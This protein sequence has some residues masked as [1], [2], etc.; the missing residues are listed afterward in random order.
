MLALVND[1]G[2]ARRDVNNE[3]A[4]DVIKLM[5]TSFFL[6]LHIFYIESET[7]LC[8]FAMEINTLDTCRAMMKFN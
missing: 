6:S 4:E 7:L 1:G 2:V 3:A 8:V 5:K